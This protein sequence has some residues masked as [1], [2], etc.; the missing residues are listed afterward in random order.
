[1]KDLESLA[2]F[3]DNLS[4]NARDLDS[5]NGE[6]IYEN[7]K[8][9]G[10]GIPPSRNQTKSRKPKRTKEGAIVEE[11]YIAARNNQPHYEG[12]LT[13]E[14]RQQVTNSV[15]RRMIEEVIDEDIIRK[16]K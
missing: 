11:A 8:R 4:K 7:S 16:R 1:M 3:F 12:D 14:E 13:P 2:N 15:V 9:I 5:Q 10:P 6:R